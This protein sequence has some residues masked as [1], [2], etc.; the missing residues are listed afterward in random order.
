MRNSNPNTGE[1][2][3]ISPAVDKHGKTFDSRDDGNNA[4]GRPVNGDSN[5]ARNIA[6]KALIMLNNE[7]ANG[8]FRSIKNTEWFSEIPKFSNGKN[9]VQT[10]GLRK[11]SLIYLI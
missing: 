3:I 4:A 11:C 6:L 5:G 8:E 2:Y 10:S 9:E 7:Q 1:D